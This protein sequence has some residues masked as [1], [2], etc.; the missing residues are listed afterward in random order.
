M[1][2]AGN[3]LIPVI[4]KLNTGQSWKRH[5]RT[6]LPSIYQSHGNLSISFFIVAAF[7]H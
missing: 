5:P 1:V 3:L 6:P 2:V 7:H 4:S